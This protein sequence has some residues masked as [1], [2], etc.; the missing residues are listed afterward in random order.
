MRRWTQRAASLV[1]IGGAGF[2]GMGDGRNP[3]A[4][5]IKM[6]N[7]GGAT[8]EVSE[9]VASKAITQGADSVEI[10]GEQVFSRTV[11]LEAAEGTSAEATGLAAA[12]GE[13]VAGALEASSRYWLYSEEERG[14]NWR[15]PRSGA[16]RLARQRHI[17]SARQGGE[18]PSQPRAGC[19]RRSRG[20]RGD[21]AVIYGLKAKRNVVQKL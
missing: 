2:G 13:T 3:F 19:E 10:G 6:E 21:V 1:V 16:D 7:A 17:E 18:E 12:G 5:F 20:N 14:R 4:K 11:L 15:L 9:E 8:E